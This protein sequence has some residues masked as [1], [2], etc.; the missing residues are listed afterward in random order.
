MVLFDA[1]AIPTM[2]GHALTTSL[3]LSSNLVRARSTGHRLRS[4]LFDPFISEST[5]TITWIRLADLAS[6]SIIF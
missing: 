3:E 4:D 6:I 2:Q 5:G 1:T